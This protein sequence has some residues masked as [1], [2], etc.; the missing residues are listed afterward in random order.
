MESVSKPKYVEVNKPLY[1]ESKIHRDKSETEK[2]IEQD[3]EIGITDMGTLL[4]QIQKDCDQIAS[5]FVE[6]DTCIETRV[7]DMI[8]SS[9]EHM[10]W[11]KT[12]SQATSLIAQRAADHAEIFR[13]ECNKL[14]KKCKQLDSFELFLLDIQNKLTLLET[15]GDTLMGTELK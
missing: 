14:S 2:Q 1:Q 12:T 5:D 13:S 3:S 4:S 6:F 8:R 11:L 9:K 7:M 15:A 10:E